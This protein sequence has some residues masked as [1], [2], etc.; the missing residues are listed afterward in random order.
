MSDEIVVLVIAVF[1]FL[2]GFLLR[3]E[4]NRAFQKRRREK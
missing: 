1:C 2:L 4:L 3:G